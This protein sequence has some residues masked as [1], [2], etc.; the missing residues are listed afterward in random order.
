MIRFARMVVVAGVAIALLLFAFANRQPVEVSF[1]PFDSHANAAFAI[2][3]PLFAVAI[4]CAMLGVIAGAFA[5]WLSQGRHRRASRH[6]RAEAEKWRAQA[7]SLRAAR[8]PSGP[9]LP[10]A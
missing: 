5:T 9:A 2:S 8:H 1:D 3:V 10:S 4:A 7:E 6:H